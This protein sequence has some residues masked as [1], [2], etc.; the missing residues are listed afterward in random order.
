MFQS[1]TRTS[2]SSS[3]PATA[4]ITAI[5]NF[6]HKAFCT[7]LSPLTATANGLQSTIGAGA[8][9]NGGVGFIL[10]I[11]ADAGV[12]FVADRHG[13]AG[14]AITLGGNPGYGV[15]G[16]GATAGAQGS[17]STVDTIYDL[18]G[19]AW[20]FGVSGSLPTGE[21]ISADVAISGPDA[22]LTVTGGLSIGGKGTALAGNYTFVP[23]L[24]STNC[25]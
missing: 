18:R 8:G 23:S 9:A 19:P 5:K 21:G 11:A 12:Q 2:L 15:F 13:N 6:I 10:G 22:T 3:A 24:L 14:V 4:P 25:R 16:V 1:D 17:I 7:A 20:D